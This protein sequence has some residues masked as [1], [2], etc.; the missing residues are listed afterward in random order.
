MEK[1]GGLCFANAGNG[2]A[3]GTGQNGWF[4]YTTEANDEGRL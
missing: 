1:A 3:G 2:Q 4:G